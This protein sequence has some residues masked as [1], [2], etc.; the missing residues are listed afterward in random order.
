MT[1][2]E[3]VR[4]LLDGLPDDCTLDDLQYHLHVAQAVARGVTDGREG[5]ATARG[6]GGGTAQVAGRV[7][8]VAWSESALVARDEVISHMRSRPVYRPAV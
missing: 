2:K 7:R 6:R 5:R 4:A 3:T 1:T 8:Q